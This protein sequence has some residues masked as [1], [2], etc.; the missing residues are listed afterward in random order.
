MRTLSALL[1][2][3]AFLSCGGGREGAGGK[4]QPSDRAVVSLEKVI[5]LAGPSAKAAAS[6]TLVRGAEIRILSHEEDF[7]KVAPT[8]GGEAWLPAGSFERLS[9]RAEREKRTK[10]VSAFPP[11][12][13]RAVEAC[14][15]LLAPDYGAARWGSLGDGDDLEVLLADHDFYGVKLPGLPLAFVPA[16]SVRLVASAPPAPP[17][18]SSPASPARPA[19][20]GVGVPAITP[21]AGDAPPAPLA[22]APP[23]PAAAPLE[24]LPPGGMPPVLVTRVEPRYPEFA[25]RAG[26]FGDVVLR[27]VV[28]A[29]GAVS[30]VQVVAGA[31]GGLSEAAVDAVRR[32]T[33][34]PAHVD[35]RPVAVVK[36]VR[37]RFSLSPT[38][39]SA[40]E[41]PPL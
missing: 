5:A 37:V 24:S 12:G 40:D 36:V 33:Y 3:S 35:G 8:D 11:Q 10:A 7:W 6:T 2:C 39:D 22:P 28:D 4:S 17:E 14:P 31:R 34:R 19:R 30:N 32:W 29:S 25:R 38:R 9:E 13:A 16:H 41:G 23:G 21:L 20:A 26:I 1:A 27:I 15:V 18:G